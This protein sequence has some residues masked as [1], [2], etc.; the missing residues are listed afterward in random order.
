MPRRTPLLVAALAACVAEPPRAL[1][2][3]SAALADHLVVF[4][5]LG[6]RCLDTLAPTI[7]I[8]ACS[9]APSQ[10][11]R[12]VELDASHDF[13]LVIPA[14][15]QCLAIGG[16]TGASL[17]VGTPLVPAPCADVAAQR[18]AFDGDALLVGRQADGARVARDLVIE[19]RDGDTRVGTALV[20]GD[21]DVNNREY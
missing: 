6:D 16:P 4:R 9:G 10:E 14:T 13:H 7:A 17:H 12:L 3:R 8:R 2:T 19:P 21:R 11:L 15:G 5:Q 20:V 18:F 1:D